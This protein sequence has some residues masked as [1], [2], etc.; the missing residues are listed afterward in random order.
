MIGLGVFLASG[1]VYVLR[2]ICNTKC[3]LT[4]LTVANA[5]DGVANADDDEDDG[6][7]FSHGNAEEVE[8]PP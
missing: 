7:P 2:S 8:A 4:L 5:D 3:F 1:S 6:P